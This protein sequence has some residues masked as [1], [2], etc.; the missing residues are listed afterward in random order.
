[1]PLYFAY[2]SNMDELQMKDRCPGA[3]FVCVGKLQNFRLFFPRYSKKRHG[4]VSS[5]EECP[6]HTVWGI[7]YRI[8]AAEIHLLDECEGY[9]E[10][11]PPDKNSYNRKETLIEGSDQNKHSSLVYIAN[12][13]KPYK[14]SKEHYLNYIIRGAEQHQHAGIPAQYIE[15]LRAIPA[16]DD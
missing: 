4:G 16:T 1:M 9:K 7:I 11:R 8:P 15:E 13:C 12:V 10:G 14:P 6:N 2:G 3:E 5:I